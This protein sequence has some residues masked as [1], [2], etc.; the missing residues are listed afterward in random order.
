MEEYGDDSDSDTQETGHRGHLRE[1]WPEDFVCNFF[2]LSLVN[3]KYSVY[4]L[5]NTT[6]WLISSILIQTCFY[7]RISGFLHFILLNMIHFHFHCNLKRKVWVF[8][9]VCLLFLLTNV[10]V[11][12]HLTQCLPLIWLSLLVP[13]LKEPK[14]VSFPIRLHVRPYNI[15]HRGIQCRHPWRNCSCILGITINLSLRATIISFCFLF[16]LFMFVEVDLPS[17]LEHFV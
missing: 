1:W 2:S 6:N 9:S 16:V 10:V 3:T 14:P 4:Y 15:T 12:V 5:P 13:L 7:M 8:E 11:V 17:S